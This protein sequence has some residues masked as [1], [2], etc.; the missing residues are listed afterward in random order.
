MPLK[1]ADL[2]ARLKQVQEISNAL[3]TYWEGILT[4]PPPVNIDLQN[5][6][7][8]FPLDSLVVGMEA[9]AG[10]ISKKNKLIAEG[11]AHNLAFTNTTANAVDY[12]AGTA[13][14]IE[15][16]ENPDET[17]PLT[18]RRMRKDLADINSPNWD[19]EGWNNASPEERQRLLRIQIAREKAA[20]L[21]GK[22]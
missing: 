9:Y 4:C 18:A 3:K 17:R 6:A 2:L 14:H 1:A 21:R 15:E 10:E 19:Q 11:K 20:K 22:R 5:L 12:I 13:H 7:R 16:R 8:R